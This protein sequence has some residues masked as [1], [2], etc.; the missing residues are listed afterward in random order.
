[1][2]AQIAKI[3]RDSGVE[4]YT[5]A[6]GYV[7]DE[8]PETVR[9]EPCRDVIVVKPRNT[10]EVARV[11]RIAY[12]HNIPVFVRGGGTGLSCGAVP[13]KTGIVL[14]TERMKRIEVDAE[15][16]CAVCSAGVTLGELINAAESKGLSF[17]PH[18]GSESATVAGMVATNAGGVRAMKYGVMRNYVI[19]LKAV[20]ADGEVLSL[21]G[22]MIKNNAGYNLMHLLIG[23][24]GTLAIITEVVLKLLPPFR[25]TLTLAVPF[26]CVEDAIRIVPKIMIESMPL[27][28][29]Y[30]E[31][32]AIT[33]GE[34][35]S[36]KRWPPRD[37]ANLMVILDGDSKD[38]L[39]RKAER[40][41]EI[42][43]RS[44]A[45]DVFVA[46]GREEKDLLAVRSLI[47]E[48]IKNDLI[49]ILDVSVPVAKIPEYIRKCNDVAEK[50]GFKVINYGHAG[51]G[52]IH[53]HPMKRVGW[54]KDY[55]G[56]RMRFFE[57]A[58]DLGGTITGEHGIGALKKDHLKHFISEREYRIM[59]EMKRIFDPKGIL[60]PGKV[61]DHVR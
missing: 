1:M 34:K 55:E 16:L 26:R 24:E 12:E 50:M 61:V 35:A 10:E 40:V 21:G 52:N 53:Q 9:I 11:M 17:P 27:A 2:R 19:G 14:S 45:V 4:P 44:N 20:L 60:N 22:K 25:E 15:N 8:T 54:E 59:Q 38:D 48:G 6:S 23:S 5:D 28:L 32:E 3:L 51:D 56:L 46:T 30:I 43:E 37:K 31:G 47:Y 36:G 7:F 18:P 42:C 41:A 57:I 29:E 39:M 33:Y 13:T 58:S 49:E